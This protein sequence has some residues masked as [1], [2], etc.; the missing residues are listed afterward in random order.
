MSAIE[1][2]YA[3]L[4]YGYPRDFRGRYGSEM[5]ELVRELRC[6]REYRGA[7]GGFRLG[8][9]L[10]NDAIRSIAR[11]RVSELKA[12]SVPL[13][14]SR[15]AE[16]PPY[17]D[18][19]IMGLVVLAVYVLTL[20]PSV[21]FWDAGEYLTVAHILGIPHSPGN[22]LF[23]LLAHG[24]EQLLAFTNLPAAVRINLFSAVMSAAAH[25]LWFLV[26]NRALRG[27]GASPAFQRLGAGLA[28]LLSATTF[29][30]WNQ[31]N[32]N[33]K[34]YTISLFTT[35]LVSWLVVRWR[36][37]GRSPKWLLSC[38]FVIVLTSTNHLMGVLVA[39]AVL[40]FVLAVGRRAL[41]NRRLYWKALLLAAIG[42]LPLFFL[43]IRAAQRPIIAE[44]EPSCPSLTSAAASIYTMGA[45]GCDVLSATLT[46]KQY[47]KPSIKLDPTVYPEQEVVRGPRLVVS[48]FINYLQYFDWQWARSI[49]GSDPLFG[50]L[51]PLV[52]VLFL[53]LGLIGA[54]AHWRSDRT[55]A[56]YLSALFLTLSGGLVLYLNFR[57]GF[58]IA[59]ETYP[60]LEMHEVRERDYFF[61]ISFSVWGLWCGLGLVSL[62]QKLAHHLEHRVR[63][64]RV[65]AA[66]IFALALLPLGLNREWASRA[67]DYF[68]RDWAYG[69]LMSV[70][71]YGVL[72]TNGDNDTFP[73]WYLQ[74]VEGIRRD[75]TVMVSTYLS[76]PWYARQV[77]DLTR[78]CQPGTS[79]S[80]EPSRIVCQRSYE[81][82]KMPERLAE[83]YGLPAA[84]EDTILPLSNEQ[85][86]LIARQP[87]I[88]PAPV[89]FRAGR[90]QGTIAAGT[91]MLPA[92]SFTA[93]IIQAS[94]GKRPV[95]FTTPSPVVHKLGLFD[96]TI[97][98]GLTY[99]LNDGAV[100]ASRNIVAMPENGIG[101]IAGAYVDL[102]VTDTILRDLG[103]RRGRIANPGLPWVDQATSNI[104]LQFAFAH[105]ALAQAYEALGQNAA[106]AREI[107][108]GVWWRELVNRGG[109]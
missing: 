66:P 36:D 12:R 106:V 30:V 76:T 40:L 18:A 82:A 97:R 22:P 17:F 100:E 104:P 28:V 91:P 19:V 51:R 105:F 48:Q 84:P 46:R 6:R 44:T 74:E 7:L 41:L 2:V 81:R 96:Y 68:S 59:R 39:P 32:V 72:F 108:D 35:A 86:E 34:V 61:L 107:D 3:A 99:R 95:H 38:V 14:G 58:S 93:A 80:D 77:R 24:F 87:F 102:T 13:C 89:T 88:T 10:M 52:T 54:R 49:S 103:V 109:E 62:W 78:P 11:E 64:A 15:S 45:L 33:E 23:V 60:S 9:F 8:I 94:L 29:T 71:P 55:G 57:Y 92:D 42:L 73:L 47:D 79:A 5:H 4:L 101:E 67:D 65:A 98:Q 1:R 50:G 70:E 25:G 31:S 43:P 53:A 63:F 75:V 21:A 83:L 85:I 20:A 90:L 69:V 56:I 27:S 26:M 37:T 16:R